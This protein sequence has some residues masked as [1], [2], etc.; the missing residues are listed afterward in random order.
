MDDAANAL[1]RVDWP[2]TIAADVKTLVTADGALSE[3][4]AQSAVKMPSRLPTGYAVYQDSGRVSGAVSI[5]RADL[6][7]P[8]ARK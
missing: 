1:L 6:G 7:L 4:C 5:V 8:P 3:R 2:P